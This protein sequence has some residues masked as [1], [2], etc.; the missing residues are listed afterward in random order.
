MEGV[1]VWVRREESVDVV[2][3]DLKVSARVYAC[4]YA[5]IYACIYACMSYVSVYASPS[6]SFFLRV[7]AYRMLLRVTL[8]E[9]EYVLCHHGKPCLV[10]FA[11]AFESTNGCVMVCVCVRV[12]VCVCV[13]VCVVC[14][15][16]KT[17]SG[18]V[19]ALFGESQHSPTLCLRRKALALCSQMLFYLRPLVRMSALR[20]MT[21]VRCFCSS[22]PA[23][24]II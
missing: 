4:L 5:C 8:H 3:K 9:S 1:K 23:P 6:V 12:C 22:P 13:C 16:Q 11:F 20:A 14:V 18:L 10:T 21:C 7:S 2:V 19:Q 24:R 17:L 15:L